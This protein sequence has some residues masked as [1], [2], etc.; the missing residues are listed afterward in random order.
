MDPKQKQPKKKGK[1]IEIHEDGQ[2]HIVSTEEEGENSE[3]AASMQ[4]VDS[5]TEANPCLCGIKKLAEKVSKGRKITII[6]ID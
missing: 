1:S 3:A 2:T 5:S 6:M 4:P